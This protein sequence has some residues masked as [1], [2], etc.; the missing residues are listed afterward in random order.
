LHPPIKDPLIGSTVDDRFRI[1]AGIGQGATSSVYKTEELSTGKTVAIKILHAHLCTNDSLVARFEREA[2]AAAILVHPNIVAVKE[3]A[4]AANGTPYLVMDFVDGISLQQKLIASGWLSLSVAIPIFTQVCAALN[5][6]HQAGI[7]HRDLKPS[8]IMLTTQDDGTRLVKILDFGCAMVMPVLGDTVLKVTQT[9]EMLGSLLYMSPE[10]CL[11]QDVDARS[12]CYALAC[13]LYETLTG[14]PP[15][16]A[17]T[18]FETMNKQLSVMPDSLA[19]VRPDIVFPKNLEKIIFKAMAKS[20]AKRYQNIVDFMDAIT[21]LSGE[22]LIGQQQS[23]RE[24]HRPEALNKKIDS[25]KLKIA[26]LKIGAVPPKSSK[27]SVSIKHSA[28]R[29]SVLQNFWRV[30]WPYIFLA[31][32]LLIVP[33]YPKFLIVI[34]VAFVWCVFKVTAEFQ[35]DSVTN[36][37]TKIKFKRPKSQSH[38]VWNKYWPYFFLAATYFCI[39]YNSAL[40]F[41]VAVVFG[42]T[43]IRAISDEHAVLS[44]VGIET[45]DKEIALSSSSKQDLTYRLAHLAPLAKLNILVHDAQKTFTYASGD[46]LISMSVSLDRST[47]QEII[48]RPVFQRSFFW[49]TICEESKNTKEAGQS[50]EMPAYITKSTDKNWNVVVI[51]S[52]QAT[53]VD[54]VAAS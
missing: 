36:E 46:A 26:A 41:L 6:A 37:S 5:V 32:T 52:N 23:S 44:T 34:A 11:D 29:K 27:H 54:T 10:Q 9:G 3:Y 16:S 14:K 33:I 50:F 20:P 4:V 31:V 15:L 30:Y 48:V 49:D 25:V 39:A 45:H 43:L 12:D 1:L 2:Q 47:Q 53:I 19:H 42:I 35:D 7:V 8:N 40:L 17:R 22:K 18:A 24:E 21:N 38:N 51:N 13:V 28:V